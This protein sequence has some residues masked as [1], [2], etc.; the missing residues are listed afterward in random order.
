MSAPFYY[1]VAGEQVLITDWVIDNEL[2]IQT[3]RLEDVALDLGRC[4]FNFEK[5]ELFE[6]ANEYL[7][8]Y[9]LARR[10]LNNVG[11]LI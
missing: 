1:E 5:K 2:E 8:G 6:E 9:S 3:S 11:E 7:D 4:V 10:V